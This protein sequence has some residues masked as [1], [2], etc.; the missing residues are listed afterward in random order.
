MF[1]WALAV[2]IRLW[3][4]SAGPILCKVTGY[5]RI[6]YSSEGE[7]AL[8]TAGGIINALPC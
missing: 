3:P 8:E 4:V 7:Q 1:S 5:P 2:D 6:A